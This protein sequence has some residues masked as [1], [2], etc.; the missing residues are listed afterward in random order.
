YEP[1]WALDRMQEKAAFERFIDFVVARLGQY[2]GLHVY[3]YGAYER[4]AL[5]RLMGRYATREEEL[6]QI[7]RAKLLVDLL[8]VVRQ[9]IRAGIESYSIKKLEPLYGFVRDAKLP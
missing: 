5:T 4:S 9:G 6:D 7:L 1:L 3:H 2:P 8:T